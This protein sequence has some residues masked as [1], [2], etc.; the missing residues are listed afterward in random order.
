MGNRSRRRFRKFYESQVEKILGLLDKH[1]KPGQLSLDTYL[2]ICEQKGIDPDPNEM[3]PTLGQYPYEVQVAFLLHDLLPDR[4]DGAS[5]S[6][7]GKDMS[8]LG[9]LLDIYEIEDKKTT[10]YFLKIIEGKRSKLLNDKLAQERKQAKSRAK[11][12]NTQASGINIKG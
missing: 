7:F 12:G 4:W 5:G 2:E 1:F 10:V 3:P 8:A 6:Y 9:S 11:A